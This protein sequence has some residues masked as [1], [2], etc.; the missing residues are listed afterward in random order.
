MKSSG[1]KAR[2]LIRGL[3]ILIS[4]F[5]LLNLV[6]ALA[7]NVSTR[8]TETDER[9]FNVMLGLEKPKPPSTFE[10]EIQ[11]IRSMQGIVLRAAPDDDPIDTYSSREPEDLLRSRS[12]L[13]YD[14]SRTIDKLLAWSGFE[15]RHVFILYPDHPQTRQ[16]LSVVRALT[17]IGTLSHAVTEARTSRGWI[18]VDSNSSWIS[19][20]RD[21]VPVGASDIPS[22]A[23]SFS[24]IPGYF[25]GPYWA[26]RGLYSRRGH[27]YRPY[28]PY[29]ELNWHDFLQWAIWG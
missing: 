26:I 25:R 22:M 12:G 20:S 3:S 27:F 11:L 21:G 13:C 18:V 9:V 6:L 19:L 29:P 24:V 2:S 5:V 4:G 8:V 10:A 28:L 17:T 7:T 1:E 23:D 16:R 14:R 15:T